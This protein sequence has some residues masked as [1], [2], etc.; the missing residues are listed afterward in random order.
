M[1]PEKV[2]GN[3]HREN[4]EYTLL[5][6]LQNKVHVNIFVFLHCIISQ[7]VIYDL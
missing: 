1:K 7:S 3:I 5:K 6:R 2:T 4:N